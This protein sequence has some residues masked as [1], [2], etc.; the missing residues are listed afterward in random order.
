MACPCYLR[1]VLPKATLCNA[2]YALATILLI[3]S[4]DGAEDLKQVWYADD[5]SATGSLSQF[6]LG[7]MSCL[8]W[9]QV[10]VIFPMPQKLGWSQS[11]S[12]WT[13]RSN[14]LTRAM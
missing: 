4:L 1:R 14:S 3:Q 8:Q 12:I 6:T 13:R 7:G 2:F 5:A 9:A 10:M 11:Q